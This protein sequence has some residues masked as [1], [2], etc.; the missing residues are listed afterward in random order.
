MT[1]VVLLDAGPEGR[2]AWELE[3]TDFYANQNG[4][5][6]SSSLSPRHGRYAM[7]YGDADGGMRV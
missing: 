7:W 1:K 4:A 6:F 3:I 2:V 5:R